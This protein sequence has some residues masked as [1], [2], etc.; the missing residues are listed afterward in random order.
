MPTLSIFQIHTAEVPGGHFVHMYNPETVCR[1][2]ND[3]LLT[4][5]SKN[6]IFHC[7]FILFN[8]SVFIAEM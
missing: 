8:S 5:N 2:I 1:L 3:F 6:S 4:K 7:S